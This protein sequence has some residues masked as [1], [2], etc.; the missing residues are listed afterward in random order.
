MKQLAIKKNPVTNFKR[1]E[2]KYLLSQEQYDGI[3]D[4]IKDRIRPDEY[5][6]ST[7]CNIYY[8]TPDF[9]LIRTSIEKP[10]YKEK[11]RLRSYGV[12]TM[13]STVFLE[14][15]KKFKKVVYKRR[16]AM[17]LRQAEEYLS[18]GEAPPMDNINTLREFD[19][20]LKRYDLRPA[21]FLAYDRQS[22]Y[23]TE[24]DTLRITFDRRIRSR[25]TDISLAKGD[26]G[27]LLLPDD[28]HLM[29]VK[30]SGALPLWLA[31]VMSEL[32]I[33][34]VSFSKYGRVYAKS[35]LASRR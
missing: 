16:S 10:V 32:K 22:Y 29:E 21:L 19:F 33:F 4:A 12:P 17:T 27:E 2:K 24:D 34:P 11:L 20:F 31:K 13:D 14:I 1:V 26:A 15:K 5:G 7:I 9:E 30:V 3:M 6:E 35:V 25:T 18:G 28:N 8:D 23:S